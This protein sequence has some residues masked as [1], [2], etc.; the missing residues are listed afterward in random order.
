MANQQHLELLQRGAAT[1]NAWKATQ[2]PD[3]VADLSAVSLENAVLAQYD[4][5]NADFRTALLW[6]CS[7]LGADLHGA[8]LRRDP[9]WQRSFTQT[10]LS[11]TNW[12]EAKIIQATLR[13]MNLKNALLTGADFIEITR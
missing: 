12:S 2:P 5:R 4:L 9:F 13:K 11:R 7:L 1:W 10:N 6:R 8:D 3:F